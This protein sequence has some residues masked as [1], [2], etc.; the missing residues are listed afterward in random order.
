MVDNR[1]PERPK[2]SSNSRKW[3]ALH[4]LEGSHSYSAPAVLAFWGFLYSRRVVPINLYG[5]SF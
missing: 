4:T 1:F 2:S 3:A 5:V